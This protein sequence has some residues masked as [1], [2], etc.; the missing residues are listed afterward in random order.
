[1][2][3]GIATVVGD[4]D[5][6]DPGSCAIKE[7]QHPVTEALGL[8]AALYMELDVAGERMGVGIDEAVGR[9]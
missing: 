6:G 2:I 4:H 1:M 8:M 7:D 3:D 9:H 5:V